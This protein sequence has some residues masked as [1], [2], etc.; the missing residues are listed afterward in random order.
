MQSRDK[1]PVKPFSPG[2]WDIDKEDI[3]VDTNIEDG[4]LNLTISLDKGLNFPDQI[5]RGSEKVLLL[6]MNESIFKEG[7]ISEDIYNKVRTDIEKLY[8]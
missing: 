4:K 7:L 8:A 1:I 2:N 6:T 3:K 5:K